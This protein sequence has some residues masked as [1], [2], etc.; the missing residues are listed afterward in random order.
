MDGTL[1]E[2]FPLAAN[3]GVPVSPTASAQNALRNGSK[4]KARIFTAPWAA[5]REWIL[6]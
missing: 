4:K 2:M 6:C 3:S 1:L 5:K